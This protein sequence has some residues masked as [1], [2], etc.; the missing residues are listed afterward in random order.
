MTY[1][2][3]IKLGNKFSP[4]DKSTQ[5]ELESFDW[6]FKK[7][8]SKNTDTTITGS[9]NLKLIRSKSQYQLI[10]NRITFERKWVSRQAINKDGVQ[11]AFYDADPQLD[12]SEDK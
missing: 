11:T 7:D 2:P 3:Y 9:K 1:K 5:K 12:I 8:P 4:T 10:E 6:T